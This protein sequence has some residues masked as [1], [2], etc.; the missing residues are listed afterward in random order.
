MGRS[1][2]GRR[3]VGAKLNADE[4]GG[5][6]AAIGVEGAFGDK[7]NFAGLKRNTIRRGDLAPL[8]T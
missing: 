2:V 4:Q 3:G 6:A 7:R 5:Y 1:G 8:L